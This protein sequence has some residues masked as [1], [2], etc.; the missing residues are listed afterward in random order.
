MTNSPLP[1]CFIYICGTKRIPPPSSTLLLLTLVLLAIHHGEA[2]RPPDEEPEAREGQEE[3]C[4]G[5]VH[6]QPHAVHHQRRQI[7]GPRAEAHRPGLERRRHGSDVDGVRWPGEAVGAACAR[8][9]S[10]F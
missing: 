9:W 7:P 3:D 1:D 2:K 5:G 10:G 6:L 4:Q 8:I